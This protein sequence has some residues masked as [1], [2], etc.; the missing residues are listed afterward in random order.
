M[1]ERAGFQVAHLSQHLG[2]DY[3]S[4]S[5]ILLDFWKENLDI[6]TARCLSEKKGTR[7]SIPD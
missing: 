6:I 5:G 4:C 7:R 1:E 3:V 2:V